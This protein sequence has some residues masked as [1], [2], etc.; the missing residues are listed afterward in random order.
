[1]K[2]WLTSRLGYHPRPFLAGASVYEREEGVYQGLRL[3]ESNL[4]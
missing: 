1:M 3:C 4:V 2:R